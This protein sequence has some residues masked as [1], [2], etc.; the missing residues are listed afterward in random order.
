[1]I[2]LPITKPITKKRAL[3]E[4][5][6]FT[7]DTIE[8]I[9][10]VPGIRLLERRDLAADKAADYECIAWLYSDDQQLCRLLKTN[11]RFPYPGFEEVD[12][13]EIGSHVTYFGFALVQQGSA[14]VPVPQMP[15]HAGK[16]VQDGLIHSKWGCGHVYEH[17][18]DAVPLK[19]GTFA[20]FFQ[21]RTL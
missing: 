14:L 15:L 20:R 10:S 5:L 16:I 1:M 13:P 4:R 11:P 6:S 8:Q 17:S 21:K 12:G 3:L 18:L 7:L 9:A 19:Y 2:T